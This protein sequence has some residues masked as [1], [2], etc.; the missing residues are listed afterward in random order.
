MFMPFAVNKPEGSFTTTVPVNVQLS[1]V[2][3]DT[4]LV[5][6]VTATPAMLKGNKLS[7]SVIP[8][9]GEGSVR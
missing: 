2:D 1:D 7:G 8:L 4:A 6:N 5:W 3:Y 9:K